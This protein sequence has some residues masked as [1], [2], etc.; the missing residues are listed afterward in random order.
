MNYHFL[1]SKKIMIDKQL[2]DK[3]DFLFRGDKLLVIK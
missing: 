1:S 3:K 2:V